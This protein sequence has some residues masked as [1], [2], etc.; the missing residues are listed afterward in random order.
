MHA[1]LTEWLDYIRLAFML[2]V[3]TL[4]WLKTRSGGSDELQAQYALDRAEY[5]AGRHVRRIE[6]ELGRSEAHNYVRDTHGEKYREWLAQQA[7][8]QEALAED[9]ATLARRLARATAR[10][11]KPG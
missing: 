6:Q 9:P 2:L 10:E 7:D 3:T 1:K 5:E 8:E 11:A 4:R